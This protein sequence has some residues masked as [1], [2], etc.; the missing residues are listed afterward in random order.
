MRAETS[1]VLDV[2]FGIRYVPPSLVSVPLT[3]RVTVTAP[4][5]GPNAN[6]FKDG[7]PLVGATDPVL[8]IPSARASDAGV[9]IY[10]PAGPGIPERGSQALALNV[11][12]Q[13][14]FLNL[15]TRAFS[16]PGDQKL[17][18]GLVVKGGPESKAVLIR[19]VGPSLAKFGI[20][21]FIKE[22]VLKVFDGAGRPHLERYDF[23]PGKKAEAIADA[24]KKV[25]AFPLA[26]GSKDAVDLIPFKAGAYTVHVDSADGSAGLALIEVYE[27]P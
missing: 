14:R 6:W 11:G 5:L 22:P 17:I 23:P 26:D 25:G 19:A 3:E 7:Q 9:Y 27:V 18:T 24:T 4:A 20:N 8:V 13:H 12:P 15:S 16:G 10:S 21:G 1:L 2:A